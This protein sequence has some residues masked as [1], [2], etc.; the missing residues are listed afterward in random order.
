MPIYLFEILYKTFNYNS[1]S[2][3]KIKVEG[4]KYERSIEL[5][6]KTTET[7]PTLYINKL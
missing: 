2:R 6:V 4:K 1:G 5:L 3:T 7:A